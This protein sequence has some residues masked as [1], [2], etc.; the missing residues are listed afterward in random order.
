MYFL[1]TKIPKK[2]AESLPPLSQFT[3]KNLLHFPV[4]ESPQFW[5]FRGEIQYCSVKKKE[6]IWFAFY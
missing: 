5:G 1:L 6:G 2:L 3:R 4:G